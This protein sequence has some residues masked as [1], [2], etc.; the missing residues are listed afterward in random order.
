MLR[1]SCH[2]SRRGL[3][4]DREDG[5]N[6]GV[7]RHHGRVDLVVRARVN[8][9]DDEVD[10]VCEVVA[11]NALAQGDPRKGIAAS[12]VNDV[13]GPGKTEQVTALARAR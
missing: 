10:L 1:W 13:S 6:L 7:L 3:P 11:R 8:A 9:V 2:R 5:P 12:P 4:A